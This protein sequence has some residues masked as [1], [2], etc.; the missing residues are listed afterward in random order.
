MLFV[1]LTANPMDIERQRKDVPIYPIQRPSTS[2]SPCKLY[3]TVIIHNVAMWNS[4]SFNFCLICIL[5]YVD[6]PF[7]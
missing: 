5:G 6:G 2:P 4:S 7:M 1:S 3:S